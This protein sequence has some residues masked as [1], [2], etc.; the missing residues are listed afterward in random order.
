[1]GALTGNASSSSETSALKQDLDYTMGSNKVFSA[2]IGSFSSVGIGTTEPQSDIQIVKSNGSEI[3]FGR[4]NTSTGNNGSLKF[5]KVNGAF[6][7]SGETSLDILNYGRGNLNFY[8][9]AGNVGV[10]TGSFY[11]HRGTISRLMALTY[12]GKLGIGR[13][14]PDN[15]LHVVGTST[16]TSNA[17]FGNN[18]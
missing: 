11:W 13:T 4:D 16:V 2:G 8:V 5:G 17:L 12:D 15:T 10:E 14:L 3:V 6:P 9:T 18:V 7:Y 1:M